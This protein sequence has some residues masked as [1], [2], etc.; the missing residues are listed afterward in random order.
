MSRYW[1]PIVITLLGWVLPSW[2]RVAR[3]TVCWLVSRARR[4][5]AWILG[6]LLVQLWDIP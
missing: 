3:V 5:L 6:V 2:W 4:K 1:L